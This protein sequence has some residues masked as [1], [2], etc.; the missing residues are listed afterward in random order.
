MAPN[1]SVKEEVRTNRREST[2]NFVALNVEGAPLSVSSIQSL[3]FVYIHIECLDRLW[4]SESEV[5]ERVG[6]AIEGLFGEIGRMTINIEVIRFEASQ[7][8]VRVPREFGIAVRCA[9]VTCAEEA[10]TLHRFTSN[11]HTLCVNSERYVHK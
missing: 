9:I 11:A 1:F 5:K 6:N 2:E 8:L 3:E 4:Q 10:I 7:A